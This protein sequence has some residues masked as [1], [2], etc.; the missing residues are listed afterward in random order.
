MGRDGGMRRAHVL[1]L[2]QALVVAAVVEGL[3]RHVVGLGKEAA[4]GRVH[5]EALGR[6]GHRVVMVEEGGALLVELVVNLLALQVQD[7]GV[8]AGDGAVGGRGG[9]EG[10]GQGGRIRHD[11]GVV[12][13]QAVAE[14]CLGVSV[15]HDKVWLVVA[16]HEG[17][18]S[19]EGVQVK[20]HAVGHVEKVVEV[21]VAVAAAAAA[22]ARVLARVSVPGGRG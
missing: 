9:H 6:R 13:E 19:V 11:G 14:V 16:G 8:Y 17:W 18:L 3:A 4:A 15:G 20:V 7:L 1:L 5:V 2:R 22:A 10:G 21:I 12:A